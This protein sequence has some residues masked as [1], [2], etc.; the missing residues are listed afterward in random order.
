MLTKSQV[1][2]IKQDIGEHCCRSICF[3]NDRVYSL[4]KVVEEMEN[5]IKECDQ[6]RRRE[7]KAVGIDYDSLHVTSPAKRFLAEW[8]KEEQ[9]R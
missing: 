1:E 6:E 7:C 8:E 5:V 9:C 3:S 4:I 2:E